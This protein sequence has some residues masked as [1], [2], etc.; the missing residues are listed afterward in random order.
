M[1]C[2][3]SEPKMQSHSIR[4]LCRSRGR[5]VLVE[6]PKSLTETEEFVRE[7]VRAFMSR[8]AARGVTSI[9]ADVDLKDW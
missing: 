4:Y 2:A 8:A 6:C 3:I 1:N 7:S 5:A 9:I